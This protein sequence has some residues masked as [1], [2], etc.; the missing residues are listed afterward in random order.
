MA[1]HRIRHQVHAGILHRG[2][3]TDGQLIPAVVLAFLALGFMAGAGSI[4]VKLAGVGFCA[5]VIAAM[6]VDNLTGGYLR[7]YV[8]THTAYRRARGVYEPGPADNAGYVVVDP[9]AT[10][11]RLTEFMP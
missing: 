8:V 10:T 2:V 6:M 11:E 1:R 3:L 7:S 9:N 5:L 4:I